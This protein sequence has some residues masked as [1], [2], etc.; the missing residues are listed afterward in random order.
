M[1]PFERLLALTGLQVLDFSLKDQ[2]F[3]AAGA[4]FKSL[5]KCFPR[6]FIVSKPPQ[7]LASYR[8]QE[9]RALEFTRAIQ[10]VNE[11]QR[12]GRARSHGHGDGT[13]QIDDGRRRESPERLVQNH[14]SIPVRLLH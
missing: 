12:G 2:A 8:R 4:Q 10:F 14:D 3:G 9:M 7:Q 13:V 1:H 5:V 6:F 11:V